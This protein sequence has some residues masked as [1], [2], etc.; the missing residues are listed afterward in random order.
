[1][2]DTLS[3]ND[4][5]DRYVHG[6]L[7]HLPRSRRDQADKELRERVRNESYGR[8]TREVLTEFGP[9]EDQARRVRGAPRQL[10][11]PRFYDTYV[12]VLWPAVRVMAIVFGGVSLLPVLVDN[13]TT[14]TIGRIVEEGL[15]SAFAGAMYAA[16]WVT[17]V[18]AVIERFAPNAV[19]RDWHPDDLPP[20]PHGH[21]IALGDAIADLVFAVALLVV[22]LCFFP[23]LA[24][25]FLA[26]TAEGLDAGVVEG[27][28]PAV[29]VVAGLWVCVAGA[30]LIVRA[31]TL[32]VTV[33]SIAA[34][35]LAVATAV[36]VLVYR[37]YFSAEFIASR[38]GG[39]DGN[40][41]T[42]LD[43]AIGIGAI[44][45]ILVC[46]NDIVTT[47]RKYLAHRQEL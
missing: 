24:P 12:R 32:P 26:E 13:D 34:N 2:T 39:N 4:L 11:G 19:L 6:V 46:A 47:V 23:A 16:L 27:L 28:L 37:P 10:I 43:I 17:V 41:G 36:A 35:L 18:F 33:I 25:S 30:Q 14:P 20:V 38:Y 8:S 15:T 29:V 45:V 9:P 21:E 1:M 40:L 7:V 31:W 42:A 22:S 44:A 3:D 5:L